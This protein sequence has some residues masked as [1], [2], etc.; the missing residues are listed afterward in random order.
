[1]TD[2]K[3]ATD[4]ATRRPLAATL[5][6]LWGL[7]Q[8]MVGLYFIYSPNPLARRFA[9]CR[10]NARCASS[11]RPGVR[12]MAPLGIFGARRS[13][14]SRGRALNWCRSSDRSR[15]SGGQSRDVR[16]WRNRTFFSRA[17][18]RRELRAQFGLPLAFGCAR[19]PLDKLYG[20]SRPALFCS[21]SSTLTN[22]YRLGFR[23]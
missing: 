3:R 23:R 19:D 11:R 1:M 22:R 21:R 15:R 10:Y 18:E 4:A 16:S 5:I 2:K 9:R 17:H 20:R 8:V 6:G 7:Y 14:D 13:N 12:R